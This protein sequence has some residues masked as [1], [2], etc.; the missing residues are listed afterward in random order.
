MRVHVVL[1]R[2]LS[3]VLA[4]ARP[5]AADLRSWLSPAPEVVVVT[6]PPLPFYAFV[7]LCVFAFA[8]ALNI[9]TYLVP[10]LLAN[11]R[12]A[13]NLRLRYKAE[14]ALVTGASSGIG[15]ALA[16]ELAEQGLNVVLVA[17]DDGL[18]A[19]TYAEIVARFPEREFRRVGVNLALADGK[20]MEPIAHATKDI[21]VSLLFN[22]AGYIVTGFFHAT[23]I[24]R[25]LANVHCNAVSAV[26]I[27]HH[28]IEKMYESGRPGLV[29]FTS[30][31]AASMPSPFTAMYSATKAFISRF[32]TSLAA[33]A[34]PQGVDVMA[35]HP[36]PVASNFLNGTAKIKVVPPSRCCGRA[37]LSHLEVISGRSRADLGLIS[38]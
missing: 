15:K 6:E 1:M 28:F 29:C 5:C 38:G 26:R 24:E 35:V 21:H 19:E 16:L 23:G 30:S 17:L 31:A 32:A 11:L 22:N 13:Q 14:W 9:M 10:Q 18:L 25:H 12:G 7:A 2:C 34:Q 20:Y 8:G 27:T 33:E 4:L 3:L 37:L 36:S